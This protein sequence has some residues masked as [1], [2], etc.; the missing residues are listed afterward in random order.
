[1][2]L[3]TKLKR[4]GSVTQLLLRPSREGGFEKSPTGEMAL[5]FAGPKGDCHSGLTRAAD[6]RTLALYKRNTDIRNVRQITLLAEE[7]LRD[8]AQELD[9]P[10]IKPEWFGANI[11][12]TGIPD[13]TLLPPSARLQFPSGATLVNDME[14]MPCRQIADVVGHHFPQAALKLVKAA[15]HK[16]GLTAWVEC[17][18]VIR[19]GDAITV[20][21]P[22]QRHYPHGT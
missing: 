7:E 21:I 4:V 11:V 19:T 10:I 13:L 3:L 12:V 17:E 9:I 8:V 15:T 6:S 5:T 20:F 14:N 18:G 1:M 22:P 2:P 16:R